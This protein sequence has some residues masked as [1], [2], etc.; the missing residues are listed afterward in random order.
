MPEEVVIPV[1]MVLSVITIVFFGFSVVQCGDF[2]NREPIKWFLMWLPWYIM[3]ATWVGMYVNAELVVS[4]TRRYDSARV[5]Y[6]DV[7]V[8]ESGHIKNLNTHFGKVIEPGTKIR[9]EDYD[10]L[11]Y[12]IKTNDQ[13]TKYFIEKEGE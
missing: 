13:H 5:K 11:Y 1:F 6:I 4:E 10:G 9:S 7:I 3:L 2:K 8:L 12:G